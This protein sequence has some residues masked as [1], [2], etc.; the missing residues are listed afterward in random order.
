MPADEG[1]RDDP[2]RKEADVDEKEG[3]QGD[4]RLNPGVEVAAGSGSSREDK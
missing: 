4:S 1:L 3:G 2:Q